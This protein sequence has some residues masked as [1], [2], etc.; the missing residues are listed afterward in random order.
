MFDPNRSK[1][2]GVWCDWCGEEVEESFY[3]VNGETICTACFPD[4]AA[5]EFA[6]YRERV[7]K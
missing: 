3:R 4:F 1:G 6:P 5:Q 2:S 7:E